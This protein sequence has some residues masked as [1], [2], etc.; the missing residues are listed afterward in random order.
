MPSL[1]YRSALGEP[2]A[3][4][5]FGSQKNATPPEEENCLVQTQRVRVDIQVRSYNSRLAREPTSF[6]LVMIWRIIYVLDLES[7][8]F[9]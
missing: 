2:L 5:G 8:S 4:L 9:F 6:L 3:P 1:K 7:S